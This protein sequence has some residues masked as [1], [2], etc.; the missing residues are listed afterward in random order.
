MTMV[1]MLYGVVTLFLAVGTG[2][3]L[4]RTVRIFSGAQTRHDYPEPPTPVSPVSKVRPLQSREE[5]IAM[6]ER[7]F[8]NSPST[9]PRDRR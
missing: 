4:T 1:I 7:Q 2:F 3:L 5:V 6:L 9:D 8:R